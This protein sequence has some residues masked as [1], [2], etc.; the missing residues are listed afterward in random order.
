MIP[1]RVKM[2]Y[3]IVRKELTEHFKTKRLII[4]GIIF[5]VVFIVLAVY[6]NIITGGT[7]TDY[8]WEDGPNRTLA[9]VMSFSSFLP[10]IIS[11]AMT[12]NSVSGERDKKSL[13]LILS[14]PIDRSS[15][16]IG[17]FLSS[18]LAISFVYALVMLVGY[19]IAA[20]LYG[21]T[22]SGSD[23]GNAFAGIGIVILGIAVWV[24]LTLMFSALLKSPTTC[25]VI[26]V[27]LWLFVL[28][29]VSQAGL[30]YF[31]VASDDVLKDKPIN[32][33][34]T[35]GS[36]S[37]VPPYNDIVFNST[38]VGRPNWDADITLYN[39]TGASYTNKLPFEGSQTIF[40]DVPFGKYTW[41]AKYKDYDNDPRSGEVLEMGKVFVD[42]IH[43]VLTNVSADKD[44]LN[45]DFNMMIINGTFPEMNASVVLKDS[46]GSIVPTAGGAF[47]FY[48]FG[49]L[50]EGR[51]TVEVT[52]AGDLILEESFYSYGRFKVVDFMAVLTGDVDEF[53]EYVS[54]TYMLNPDSDMGVSIDIVEKDDSIFSLEI[55]SL[56]QGLAGLAAWFLITF[57]GGMIVFERKDPN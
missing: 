57:I 52:I 18:F 7:S 2:I 14:K 31:A 4:F 25:I 30:I 55:I 48:R 37:L 1:N 51:Y 5:A 40:L 3:E 29:L 32:V 22:V 44:R 15:V 34:I 23:V 39:E 27:I 46:T 50:D 20:G 49:D 26:M 41:E 53:P 28:P 54:Y 47:G 17:K 38:I 36:T 10:A 21:K 45:N 56:E 8:T 16:F 13:I 9:A 43:M 19:G 33:D 6:G 11:V 42:G 24:S 35:M 12:Y